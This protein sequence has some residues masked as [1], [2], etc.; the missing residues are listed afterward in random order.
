MSDISDRDNGYA[1]LFRRMSEIHE[2]VEVGILPEDN[3]IPYGNDGTTLA[4][5]AA[6][7]EFGGGPTPE[8][9]F[10]RGWFDANKEAAREGLLRLALSVLQGKRTS[11][12]AANLFG[13]W[14]SGEIKKR[15]SQGI[16]PPNERPTV[17]KKGS[18]TPLIDHGVLRTHIKH[19]L[20]KP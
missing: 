20:V 10:I 16:P 19:R 11:E 4:D 8:R 5:V 12:E 18:S 6:Y 14:V 13:L 2:T 3:D 17:E 7:N 9:S 15:I 1:A